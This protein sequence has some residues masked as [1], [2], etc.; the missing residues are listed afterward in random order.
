MPTELTTMLARQTDELLATAG[1]FTDEEVLLPSRC[2][3]WSRGHVLSHL[4]RNAD[5][6]A[7]GVRGVLEGTGVSMYDSDEARDADV[8]RGAHRPVTEHLADLRRSSA[9]LAAAIA[10]ADSLD[11]NLPVLRTPD[12][13]AHLVIGMV[14]A[15]RL[16]EVVVHHLDLRADFAGTDVDDE[17]GEALLTLALTRP[18]DDGARWQRSGPDALTSTAPEPGRILRGRPMDLL[19]FLSRGERH[20]LSQSAA[21]SAEPTGPER[22]SEP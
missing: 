12:A 13:P 14:P 5:G 8:E 18:A 11:P 4:S 10:A 1:T 20:G 21:D 2:A 7:R 3:G 15:M 22:P 6:L 17:T 9:A 19:G 16:F